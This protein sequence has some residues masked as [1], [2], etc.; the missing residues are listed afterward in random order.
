MLRIG[1]TIGG[2]LAPDG[3]TNVKPF[4]SVAVPPPDL[5]TTSAAPAFGRAATVAMRELAFWKATSVALTPPT[6]TV[7]PAAKLAP[8]I[9]TFVPPVVLPTAG[10][11]PV[12]SKVLDGAVVDFEAQALPASMSART[13]AR[14]MWVRGSRV[15]LSKPRVIISE[16]RKARSAPARDG[17]LTNS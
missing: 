7:A 1:P 5:T 6:V 8:L 12:I 10:R 15:L 13:T 16:P 3:A 4:A 17:V 11:M 2:R 9:N 14:R